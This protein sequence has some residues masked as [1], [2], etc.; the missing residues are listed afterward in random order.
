VDFLPDNKLTPLQRD[1]LVAFFTREQRFFLTGGAALAG[2]YF[3]HRVTEDLDLFSPPGP[4]LQDAAHALADSALAC[5]ADIEPLK[6]YAEY[7]RFIA[8]R[9]DESCI[10]DL[11]I[12]RA[13][14]VDH[15]KEQRGS[16]RVDTLRDIAANKVCTLLGRAE[17]KDLVDFREL[18]SHGADLG[19]ALADAER[20][21]GGADPATLAWLLAQVTIS[22]DALLPGGVDPE[23]LDDFRRRL[24]DQLHEVAYARARG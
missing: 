19:T 24:V 6:T 15:T 8:R 17:A 23:A 12:D 16:I 14:Q 13:P 3:G 1:L 5:E 9:G 18:L 22:R 4:D 7:R 2:F 11:V 21:D 10:I 20:K